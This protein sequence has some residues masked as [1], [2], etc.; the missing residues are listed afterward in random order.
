MMSMLIDLIV[1]IISQCIHTSTHH[2]VHL[3]HMQFCQLYLNKAEGKKTSRSPKD[4]GENLFWLL[5][6]KYYCNCFWGGGF[7]W[8][9]LRHMEVPRLGGG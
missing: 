2:T 9:H 8:L 4:G 6:H 1:V 5:L 3:K 7:L